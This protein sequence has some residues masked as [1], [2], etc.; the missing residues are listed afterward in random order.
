MDWEKT[1]EKLEGLVGKKLKSISGKADITLVSVSDD[2]VVVKSKSGKKR[3]P[4]KELRGLVQKLSSGKP[5]H[6]DSALHGGGSSRNQPETI[7]ANLPDVEWL[8]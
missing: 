1:F 2:E 4:T 6:V 3:R 5:V 7:L 8:H